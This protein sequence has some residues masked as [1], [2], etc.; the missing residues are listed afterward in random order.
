MGYNIEVSINLMKQSNFSELENMVLFYA[1]KYLCENIYSFSEEEGRT[2][3]PRCHQIILITFSNHNFDNLLEFIKQI[4]K[5]KQIHVEC[6]YYEEIDMKLIYA[7]SYYLKS[8]DKSIAIKYN[9]YKRERS[10]S[11]EEI[12]VINVIS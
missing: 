11:E 1:D 4:K 7:S 2:K 12:R 5:I 9:T 10:Y 6:V 8:I 3:I